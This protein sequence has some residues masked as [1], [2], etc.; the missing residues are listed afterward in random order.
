MKTKYFIKFIP[1]Y[2]VLIGVSNASGHGGVT[3][4][5]VITDMKHKQKGPYAAPIFRGK[6]LSQDWLGFK[7]KDYNQD[8]I[9]GVII[10]KLVEGAPAESEGLA[11]GDIITGANIAKKN[12]DINSLTDL[13]D[14]LAG[15]KKSGEVE[16]NIIRNSKKTI[17]NVFLRTTL[18]EAAPEMADIMEGKRKPEPGMMMDAMIAKS[19]LGTVDEPDKLKP[20]MFR[21]EMMQRSPMGRMRGESLIRRHADPLDVFVHSIL[22]KIQKPKKQGSGSNKADSLKKLGNK[23]KNTSAQTSRSIYE[24]KKELADILKNKN[25]DINILEAQLSKINEMQLKKQKQAVDFIKRY[26][27][28]VN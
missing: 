4:S 2:I 22:R 11:A 10:T 1:L 20:G 21:E 19:P 6:S 24:M 27:A 28:L 3:P 18:A 16:F 13:D 5:Q 7:G 9:S 25:I 12:Y 14:F 26:L 15:L 17:K 8:N 23:Y